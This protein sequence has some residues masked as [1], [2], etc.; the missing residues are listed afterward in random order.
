M[1]LTATQLNALYNVSKSVNSLREFFEG[2]SGIRDLF[3]EVD[4]AEYP[5][6]AWEV[7][8]KQ[9]GQIYLSRHNPVEWDSGEFECRPLIYGD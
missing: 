4:L 7:T 1:R 2:V 3:S 8:S 5:A 6:V 9:T